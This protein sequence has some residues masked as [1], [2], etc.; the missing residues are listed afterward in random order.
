MATQSGKVQ[1]FRKVSLVIGEGHSVDA[2]NTGGIAL[3]WQ[4]DAVQVIIGPGGVA[5]F[6][7]LGN[8]YGIITAN[9]LAASDSI[10]FL[11]AWLL[12]GFPKPLALLDSGGRTFLTDATTM[13]RQRP[14]IVYNGADNPWSVDIHCPTLGGPIGGLNN[15]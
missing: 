2:F 8:A 5:M 4:G 6:V 13:P 15:I 1:D 14:N 10:D 12:S 9:L 11:H 7:A 3:N